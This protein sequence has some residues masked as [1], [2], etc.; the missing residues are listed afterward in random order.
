MIMDFK[1]EKAMKN[2]FHLILLCLVVPGFSLQAAESV[3]LSIAAPHQYA[4]V[5]L[6]T[7]LY[8][9]SMTIEVD[10]RDVGLE[11]ALHLVALYQNGHDELIFMKTASGWK[12]WD[13]TIEGLAPVASK[14]LESEE[15]LRLLKNQRLLAGGLPNSRS[16][17]YQ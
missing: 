9:G 6:D 10:D 4:D 7:D 12:P 14:E 8:S 11:G 1:D 5:Y 15:V 16:L 13:L 2:L 17:F 3:Q